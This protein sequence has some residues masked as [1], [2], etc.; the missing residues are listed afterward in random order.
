MHSHDFCCTF[1]I[2]RQIQIPIQIKIRHFYVTRTC[3]GRNLL[4]RQKC[5]V[6]FADK[7]T[8]RSG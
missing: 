1:A 2:D 4:R 6:S 8:Q 7:Q 3:D 5:S